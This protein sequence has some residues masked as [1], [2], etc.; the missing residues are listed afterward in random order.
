MPVVAEEEV[1]KQG[2]SDIAAVVRLMM[3][4]NLK[5]LN[6]CSIRTWCPSSKVSGEVRRKPR[7]W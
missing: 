1:A 6:G 7:S 2:C 4:P 3:A 5:G